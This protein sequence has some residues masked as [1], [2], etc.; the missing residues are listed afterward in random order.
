MNDPGWLEE[1]PGFKFLGPGSQVPG[2][3]S[4]FNYLARNIQS[5]VLLS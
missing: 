2:I 4:R 1:V 3:P 5:S